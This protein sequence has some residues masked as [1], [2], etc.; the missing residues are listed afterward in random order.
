MESEPSVDDPFRGTAP[1]GPREPKQQANNKTKH[2]KQMH[3]LAALSAFALACVAFF[4]PQAFFPTL[5]V[6]GLGV[7]VHVV[8]LTLSQAVASNAFYEE[9]VL[10][11]GS[12]NYKIDTAIAA[13]TKVILVKAGSD[14]NHVDVCG[15]ADLHIGVIYNDGGAAHAAGEWATVHLLS[16]DSIK[17]VANAA[18]TAGSW[19]YTADDGK[20][21]PKPTATGSYY[22]VGRSLNASAADGDVLEIQPITPILVKGL[23]LFGNTNSEISGLTI[24]ASY[25]QAELQALRTAL[26]ELADDVR[27]LQ[28][29]QSE[30]CLLLLGLAS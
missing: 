11:Q 15:A 22:L 29:A 21:Q 14:A 3:I 19:C 24:G 28:T 13:G 6:L 1:A 20:V 4:A 12:R 25:S 30:P 7:A 9:V 26:E 10:H 2:M 16:Q 23:A 5:A 18:I 17:A 27:A 8:R